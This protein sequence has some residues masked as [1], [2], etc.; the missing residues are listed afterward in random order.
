MSGTARTPA[1]IERIQRRVAEACRQATSPVSLFLAVQ[2]AL[3]RDIPTDRWC[4]MT[5]DPATSL[6]TGG[7]H[8]HGLSA[9]RGQRLLELEFGGPDDANLLA[10]LA[11]SKTG[12]VNTLSAA[13]QGRVETSARYREVLSPDGLAH[14]LRAVFRDAHGPWGA[15]VMLR[16][17]DAPDFDAQDIALLS[18][19]SEPLT[20]ALRRLLLLAEMEAHAHPE[21]PALL[22]LESDPHGELQLRHTS[23]TARSW[24]AQIDDSTAGPLPYALYS[25][26]MTARRDGHGVARIRTR[27]GRW[28]TAHAETC[29]AG[30]DPASMPRG[31]TISLIL[32]PSRPHEIAQVLSAAY[33]LTSREAEVARLVAAGCPNAE[34]ANL[35]FVSRYT[36]EDHLKKAYG[37]LGVGSRSELVSRLFFDQYLPRTKREIELDGM[38]W[39]MGAKD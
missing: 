27:G 1:S 21:A 15:M 34:I 37:K 38:G 36:V 25:I 39:F 6:P 5:L 32:Q 9:E 33:G 18:A 10:D 4:A 14:E 31:S 23:T 7:V 35:L 29:H 26:A 2:Q 11:R 24:L 19:I 22:L 8:E 17:D 12:A 3:D 16:G 30:P 20:R 13:T 28:L